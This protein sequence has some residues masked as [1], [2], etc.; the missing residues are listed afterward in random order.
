MEGEENMWLEISSFIIH[1]LMALAFFMLIPLPFFLKGMEGENLLFIKKL[2]RPIMHFAHVGLIGSII[3]GIFL[4][5]NGLSWWIIVVFVL[6]L[7]IGALLGL[8]AKNLRL[9]MENNNKDRSLLRF[10]YI[11]TVAILGMFILKFAN[12]F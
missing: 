5:Q 11:L 4:I 7:T 3:T 12:W 1:W 10:S 6:W 2:Y 8:T 9:S